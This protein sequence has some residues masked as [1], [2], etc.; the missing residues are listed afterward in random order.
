MLVS[1]CKFFIT[2]LGDRLEKSGRSKEVIETGH[3]IDPAKKKRVPY[4]YS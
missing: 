4:K 1:V 3:G 2:E